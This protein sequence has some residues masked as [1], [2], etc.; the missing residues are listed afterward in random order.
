MKPKY[1][2]KVKIKVSKIVNDL[3]EELKDVPVAELTEMK[4]NPELI[5]YVCN[6]VEGYIKKKYKCNKKEIVTNILIKLNPAINEADKKTINDVVEYLH[7]NGDIV[8]I[9]VVKYTGKVLLRLMKLAVGV[10]L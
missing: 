5:R 4:V 3:K 9:T 6:I 10:V 7:S 2:L 1:Q 8:A